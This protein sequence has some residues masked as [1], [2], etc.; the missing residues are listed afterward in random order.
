MNALSILHSADQLVREIAPAVPPKVQQLA[1]HLETQ[2]GQM[3]ANVAYY[4]LLVACLTAAIALLCSSLL[5]VLNYPAPK[6]A[7]PKLRLIRSAPTNRL[8]KRPVENQV[9]KA[10]RAELRLASAR[11]RAGQLSN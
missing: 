8:P 3:L 4:G 5:L 2:T 7:P 6:P 11:I 9:A 10:N 1:N